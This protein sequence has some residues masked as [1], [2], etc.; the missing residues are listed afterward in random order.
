MQAREAQQLAEKLVEFLE[1][2]ESAPDLFASDV[3]LD[4]TLPRWRIQAQGI[5]Q[6][7]A[8]RREG[9]HVRGRIP[10]WR[11]DPTETGFVLEFE[12][13]WHHAGDDWYA[14]ELARVEVKAGAIAALSVYC[15]GDWDSA[16]EAEHA[17]EVRML[18]P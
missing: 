13:R 17:R 16:R 18:R 14:R 7:V 12:E 5:A 10:R 2:G 15:T 3:F 9:G 11:C 4:L 1:T 8:V 6:L